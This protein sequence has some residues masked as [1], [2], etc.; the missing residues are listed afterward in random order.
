M[1]RRRFESDLQFELRGI[2]E[3]RSAFPETKARKHHFVPAFALAQFATPAEHRKGKLFQLEVNTGRP[4]RTTPNDAAFEIELYTYGDDSGRVNHMEAF[5]SI[6][7]KHAAR[8]L[9]TLREHPG[10]L[11]PEDRQTIAYFLALQ[12]SRTPAGLARGVRLQ[13]ATVELLFGTELAT[14]DG[15]R[16][17]YRERI[18]DGK[19]KD[20]IEQ[21]RLRMQSQLEGGQI[22]YEEPR[23]MVFKL[24]LGTL[25][26]IAQVVYGLDWTVV[27]A[28]EAD[29]VASDRPVAMV[30]PTPEHP[31]SGNAWKSSPN[32]ITF[33]PL[34][35]SKGLLLSPGDCGLS[36]ATSNAEQV[37]RLNLLTYGWA[38]RRIFGRSQRTLS[39][40]RRQAKRYPEEIAR[41]RPK[42]QVILEE[43][44]PEDPNVGAENV[45]K[46]WPR[47]LYVTGDDGRR[48]FMRYTVV[49][50][51][52][53]P[54]DLAR[55]A[56][57]VARRVAA[58]A[59]SRKA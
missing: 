38:E 46:G 44:D 29:F 37:R 31:W 27:E 53:E 12:E 14:P 33:Y 56:G 28:T 34:S 10:D 50:F 42:R 21:L 6:V 23:A 47:G 16:S 55:T 24:M 20:E 48:R 3:G 5:L 45:R 2:A 26:D 57:D 25:H 35:P 41:P 8:A 7:E 18:G 4:Q 54:G 59:K 11:S 49:D 17:L 9:R 58:A 52:A 51:E 36:G 15:F 39:D 19:R 13:Q 43:A 1:E 22:A 40:V 32:A 30:D